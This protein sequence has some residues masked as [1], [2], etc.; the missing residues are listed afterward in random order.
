MLAAVRQA[1]QN[2]LAVAIA[3]RLTTQEQQTLATATELMRRLMPE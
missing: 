1:K 3:D 2:W